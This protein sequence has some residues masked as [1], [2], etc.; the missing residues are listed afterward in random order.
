MCL[1]VRFFHFN[2]QIYC[3]VVAVGVRDGKKFSKRQNDVH[4]EHYK[5]IIFVYCNFVKKIIYCNSVKK[6]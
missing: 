2:N 6:I 3:R 1:I 4:V 5:V